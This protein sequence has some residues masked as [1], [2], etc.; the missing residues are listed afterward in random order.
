MFFFS[1]QIELDIKYATD[2]EIKLPIVILP[3]FESSERRPAPL[4]TSSI[5]FEGFK[6]PK[7]K[8]MSSS[9][10][11]HAAFQPEEPPPAYGAHQMYPLC[12][13]A[14]YSAM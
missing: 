13:D 10:R 2:P 7:N 4:P 6:S 3:V 12:P 8:E 1:T 9:P 11:Q 5:G 14:S